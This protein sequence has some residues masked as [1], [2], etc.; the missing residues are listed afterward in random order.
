MNFLSKKNVLNGALF[1]LKLF[2]S[3]STGKFHDGS[4]IDVLIIVHDRNE[5]IL[6]AISEVLLDVELKYDAKISP[7]VLTVL[8]FL[9]NEKHQ[10]LFFH[11]VARN[12]VTL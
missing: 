9:Q 12:G 10:T 1:D 7:V 3:K 2:G 8:E 4:D 5:Q 6:D 11:E